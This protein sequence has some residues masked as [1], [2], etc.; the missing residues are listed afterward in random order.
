VSTKANAELFNRAAGVVIYI[1]VFPQS[2]LGKSSN[3]PPRPL[4]AQQQA[5]LT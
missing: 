3:T 2:I 1:A 5:L 4:G